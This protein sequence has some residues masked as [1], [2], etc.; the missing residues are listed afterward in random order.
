MSAVE[1]FLCVSTQWRLTGLADGKLFAGGLDYAAVKAGLKM[2]G[3]KATKRLLSELQMIELG[4]RS[5]M[6]GSSQ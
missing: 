6:N 2:A 5:A 3:I 1:A 4:A